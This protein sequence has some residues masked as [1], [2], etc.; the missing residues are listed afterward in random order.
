MASASFSD[1]LKAASDSGATPCP[2]GTYDVRV[3]SVETKQTAKGK[4][5]FVIKYEIIGGPHGGRKVFNRMVISP[6]SAPALGFFFREMRAMGLGQDY[7]ANN[8]TVSQVAADL[9]G[10]TC[11]IEVANELYNNEDRDVVKKI[12]PPSAGVPAAPMPA[13][14][15]VVSVPVAKAAP[16]ADPMAPTVPF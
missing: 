9:N 11:R 14:T 6:E 3:A 12:M 16:A 8:P 13:A 10:R 4:D 7:F 2:P 5:M 15:S 1:L